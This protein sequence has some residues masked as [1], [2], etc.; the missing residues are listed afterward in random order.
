MA[1]LEAETAANDRLSLWIAFDYGGRAEL[2]EAAR[3]LIEAGVAPEDVDEN[4]LAAQLYAPELPDPDLLIRTSGELR[5]SNFLLW[6]L[7]YAELVFVETLWPDFGE[8]DLRGAL[9]DYATPAAA[10]R[11]TMSNFVSRVLVTIVGVP[12]VLYLVYL[13]DWWLFGLAAFAALIALHEFYVMARSLRPLVLAGYAGALAALLGAELGGPEWMIGGFMLTLVLAFLL[14]GIAETRQTATVTMSST[15]LGVAWIALGLGHL[16]LLRDFPEHG[17]L[18]VFTVL[19]AVFADDTAAY[20]IGRLLGRHKLA[21]SLSPGKTWEGF[22]AGTLA[23]IA[24]AFFALYE[25]DFLS[26]PESIAL[27]A[28]VALAGAARRPLRV[29]AQARPAGEGLG[30]AARRPRRHA[31]PDRLAALRLGR[32][33]LRG[34]G[35]GVGHT[36]PVKRIALLGA[37]GS[38]GRQA[39]EVVERNPELEL[40]ALAS[41]TSD[42]TELAREHGVPH[43]QV[44]GDVTELLEAAR[45]RRRPER[46]RRLRRR[47]RDAVGARARRHARAREQGEPRRCRRARARGEG[48]GRRPAAAGR[49]RALRALPVPR[50]PRHRLRSTRSS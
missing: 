6:Q 9:A 36:V 38:I 2:V 41:G 19:L 1:A 48:A 17:R 25:Q 10:L 7:A 50:G 20:L 16:L 18:A 46:D 44:G 30:P 3:R 15:V 27:G 23:A 26:I 24:V 37:T 42:L 31:R 11:R 12:V 43:T 4:A 8:D 35:P 40:C 5:L 34:H 13:G 45:A 14:Y 29:G 32:G 39:I 49:L 21:P 28:A 47:R 33:L 22:V